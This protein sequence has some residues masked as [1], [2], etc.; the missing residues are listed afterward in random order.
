VA[1]DNLRQGVVVDFLLELVGETAFRKDDVPL[2][3]IDG[4]VAIAYSVLPWSFVRSLAT[5]MMGRR[6]RIVPQPGLISSVEPDPA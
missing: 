2:N 1:E 6:Q 3:P 5:I 4:T